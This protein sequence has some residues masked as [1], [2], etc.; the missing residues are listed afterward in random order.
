MR[1]LI[2]FFVTISFPFTVFA[3]PDISKA[4]TWESAKVIQGF[5]P[6]AVSRAGESVE[7]LDN[8]S[9]CTGQFVNDGGVYLTALHCVMKSIMNE[10]PQLRIDMGDSAPH[11]KAWF[12]KDMTLLPFQTRE[13]PDAR[14]LHAQND[15]G[16]PQVLALGRGYFE[17]PPLI[18]SMEEFDRVASNAG[19]FSKYQEDFGILKFNLQSPKSHHCISMSSVEPVTGQEAWA[20]GFPQDFIGTGKPPHKYVTKAK[21]YNTIEE[22]KTINGQGV[23]YPEE[24]W[25]DS[26]RYF[27]ISGEAI[28]GMSGGAVLN[29]DGQI[30]GIIVARLTIGDAIVLRSSFV[31]KELQKKLSADDFHKNFTCSSASQ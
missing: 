16:Q 14:E 7:Y 17:V 11:Y 25:F 1:N 23:I 26:N 19:E 9:A 8:G 22:V 31:S 4:I 30:V 3:G 5:M 29:I 20:I 12:V 24:A 10:G 27:L 6:D 15:T 28:P 21:I 18:S 2:T 13:I